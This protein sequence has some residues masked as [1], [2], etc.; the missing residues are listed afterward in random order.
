MRGFLL[1]LAVGPSCL[2]YCAPAMVPFMLGEERDM[3]NNFGVVARFLIGRFFGY[4]GF[5]LLAWALNR[6]VVQTVG[7]R[8]W[9]FGAAY[10]LLAALLAFYSQSS[11]PA[12]CMAKSL[13]GARDFL[14]RNWP[15]LLPFG[16]GFFTGVSL[17]PPF[18]LAF[19]EAANTDGFW[20]VMLFFTTFF[21]GTSIFFLPMPILGLLGRITSMRTVAKLAALIMSV[22]YVYLGIRMILVGIGET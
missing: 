6:F 2:V 21:L 20:G 7:A 12:V 22:F 8:E 18:L 3:R 10:I 19:T 16:L 4:L 13:G 17:C 15:A 5:A 1:G 9:M 11:R 14:A